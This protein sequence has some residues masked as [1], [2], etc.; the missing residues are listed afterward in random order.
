V[1][2][3]CCRARKRRANMLKLDSKGLIPAII[4]D[5]K[6][7]QVLMLG[8]MDA[9]AISRTLASGQVWFYSR[10]RQELWHKGATSGSFLNLK[11]IVA[12]CDQDALVLQ[13]EPEGPVCH[14]GAQSCFFDEV[15]SADAEQKDGA[16]SEVLEELYRVILD[17]KETKPKGSYVSGLL[18]SGLNRVAQKVI[19]EGGEVALAKDD[20]PERLASEVADLF[21]HALILLAARGVTPEAVWQELRMRRR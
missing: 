2:H 3:I 12:D 11:G 9:E 16:G 1:S 20:P 21:F 6:T 19:E 15:K 17:R 4:Q 10:S 7:H 5:S 18:E 13:V 8:Y 14:T